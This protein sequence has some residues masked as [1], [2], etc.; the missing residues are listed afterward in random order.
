MRLLLV[1]ALG[2]FALP[3][4]HACSGGFEST[5]AYTIKTDIDCTALVVRADCDTTD[6]EHRTTELDLKYCI[7]NSDGQLV[8]QKDGFFT[9][10]CIEWTTDGIDIG[11]MCLG[12]DGNGWKSTV[13]LNDFLCNDHGWVSCFDRRGEKTWN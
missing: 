5:C 3:L 9:T 8:A 7:A 2:L 12:E 6:F 13:R 1:L 11:A 10:S 4:A